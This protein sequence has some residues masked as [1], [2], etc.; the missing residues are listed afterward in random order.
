MP[1]TRDELPR[2]LG[3]PEALVERL[4]SARTQG[5]L[6]EGLETDQ[7]EAI[8]EA[9]ERLPPDRQRGVLSDLET[10]RSSRGVP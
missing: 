10:E 3:H 8:I 6:L 7:L 1:F 5:G 4:V 9:V 2:L